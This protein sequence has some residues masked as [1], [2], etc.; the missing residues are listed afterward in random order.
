[1]MKKVMCGS[2]YK[3]KDG[4]IDWQKYKGIFFYGVI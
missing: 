3:S 2:G 4:E 1:M